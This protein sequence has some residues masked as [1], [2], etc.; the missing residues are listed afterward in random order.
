M[1]ILPLKYWPDTVG[2]TLVELT[3]EE[4][5]FEV[6][7]KSNPKSYIQFTFGLTFSEFGSIIFTTAIWRCVPRTRQPHPMERRMRDKCILTDKLKRCLL[8]GDLYCKF[9]KSS[10][11][12]AL[13][14]DEAI[15]RL[16]K[17]EAILLPYNERRLFYGP[18]GESV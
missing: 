13:A 3:P 16:K 1:R 10:Y 18:G 12:A 17:A 5:T 11:D 2:H 8:N 15:E 7:T 14:H 4:G 9:L 6:I